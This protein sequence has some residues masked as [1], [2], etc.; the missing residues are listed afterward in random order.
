MLTCLSLLLRWPSPQDLS[1]VI[2]LSRWGVFLGDGTIVCRRWWLH[3]TEIIQ[4]ELLQT[5]DIIDVTQTNGAL[6]DQS[7][8][9]LKK[10]SAVIL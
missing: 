9:E 10:V 6:L 8:D 2:D 5:K 3:R 4:D 7:S 1:R